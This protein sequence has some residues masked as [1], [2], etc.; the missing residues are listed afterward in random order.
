MLQIAKDVLEFEA[1]TVA[2]Q[3]KSLDEGFLGLARYLVETDNNVFVAGIGKSGIVARSLS[4]KLASVGVRSA[5][6]SATDALHGELGVLRRDDVL[7]LLSNSGATQ[8]VVDVGKAA[9]QRGTRIAAMVAR[10]PSPLSRMAQWT[11]QVQV[12]REAT[13]M[14]LPTA[15]TIAMLALSDALV[16]AVAHGR[17]VTVDDFARNHPGGTL[18]VLIGSRVEDHMS[19]APDEVALVGPDQTM[20][21]ALI[22]MTQ[23]P[24][25]AA[26]V[27]DAQRT[28]LG[29]ITDGDVR[30][31]LTTHSERFL[32]MTT[33]QCMTHSPLTCGVGDSI[34]Q[35]L[36]LME[37]RKPVYV[38]PVLDTDGRVAGLLRM[39]AIADL[40]MAQRDDKN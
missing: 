6:L 12:E 28:L 11:L 25:G 9:L 26:L 14:Q 34:M 37:G 2:A 1:K 16:L 33:A 4:A 15:S 3:I 39:H 10:V 36:K 29:I 27:V 23:V 8:E 13:E 18:G 31:G 22:R 17:G 7:I 35:A 40:E 24:G 19:K 21:D 38:L 30:R 32:T 20:Q 5:L